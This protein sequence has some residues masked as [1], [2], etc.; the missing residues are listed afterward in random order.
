MSSNVREL[1]LNIIGIEATMNRGGGVSK[2][3][4]QKLEEFHGFLEKQF[5]IIKESTDSNGK[6]MY[7]YAQYKSELRRNQQRLDRAR[8]VVTPN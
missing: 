3:D 8:E 6:N 5:E 7:D 2:D 4:I 1:I